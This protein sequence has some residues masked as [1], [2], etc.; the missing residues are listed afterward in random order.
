MLKTKRPAIIIVMLLTLTATVSGCGPYPP[1]HLK[2]KSDSTVKVT[3]KEGPAYEK[4][5]WWFCGWADSCPSIEWT[6][7]LDF[8]PLTR[9]RAWT[10]YEEQYEYEIREITSM[11]QNGTK[12]PYYEHYRIAY[13]DS[14]PTD[15]A[16]NVARIKQVEADL[17]AKQ[18]DEAHF[19]DNLLVRMKDGVGYIGSFH[20]SRAG[21]KDESRAWTLTL[22]EN[23]GCKKLY[24]E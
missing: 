2:W 15:L 9:D 24:F 8:T 3:V 19:L 22:D 13:A 4:S 12:P 1:K 18:Q 10:I 14:N 7:C 17:E 21:E 11:A 5:R 16:K 20:I 6:W 23:N